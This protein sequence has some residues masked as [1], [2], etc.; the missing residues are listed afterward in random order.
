MPGIARSRKIIS[1]RLMDFPAAH[2]LSPR[3]LTSRPA[4]LAGWLAPQL[5]AL[6]LAVFRVPLWARFPQAGELMALPLML[7]LQ[8]AAAS[9]MLP[10]V[11]D[12]T[13]A[14]IL[15]LAAGP[16]GFIAGTLSAVGFRTIISGE[17]NVALWIVSVA[18]A[19]ISCRSARARGLACAHD[20]V[21]NRRRFVALRAAGISSCTRPAARVDRRPAR[22]NASGTPRQRLFAHLASTSSPGSSATHSLIF[23]TSTACTSPALMPP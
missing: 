19:S 21:V 14:A 22:R 17:M 8:I 15:L 4:L 5:A 23:Q 16:M 20:D 10:L 2:Q 11:E 6:A 13:Q 3:G 18:A 9:V 7:A 12:W 1:P